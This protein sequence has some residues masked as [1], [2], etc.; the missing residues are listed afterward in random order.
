MIPFAELKCNSHGYEK[1]KPS[2]FMFDPR[3]ANRKFYYQNLFPYYL[4]RKISANKKV[5]DIGFGY[6]HGDFYLAE[7]AKEVI[8]IDCEKENIENA[9]VK[10]KKN[11]LSYNLMDA[12]NLTFLNECFDVVC[13]FQVIEHIKEDLLLKFLFEIKR[14]LK[15]QCVFYVSTLNKEVTM[16][17]SQPYDKNVYHNKEFN[18]EELSELLLRVFNKVEMYGLQ[19]TAKHKFFLRLKKIGLFKYFPKQANPVGHF[20]NNISLKDFK[21]SKNNLRQSLDFI[22]VC[23]K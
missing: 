18:A 19:L 14:V 5:L 23:Q 7:T 22:C 3:K 9:N 2:G 1:N 8:A 12:T 16:K 13:S 21:I 10:F 15:P 6:G 11:N 4:V 20:Y 17:A